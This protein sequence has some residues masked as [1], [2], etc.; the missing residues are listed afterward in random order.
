[1]VRDVEEGTSIQT[2]SGDSQ[3]EDVAPVAA[4]A[5]PSA[6]AA[7]AGARFLKEEPPKP[8]DEGLL[9]GMRVP[10]VEGVD[11]IGVVNGAFQ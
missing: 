2:P 10:T 9:R 5:V 7:G 8:T 6:R 4:A 1:M 11:A 3:E